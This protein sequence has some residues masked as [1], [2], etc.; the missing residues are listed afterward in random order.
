MSTL[1]PIHDRPD[2]TALPMTHDAPHG[3]SDRLA[4][5]CRAHPD[6]AGAGR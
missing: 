3:G 6:A 2:T 4:E 1:A 5:A